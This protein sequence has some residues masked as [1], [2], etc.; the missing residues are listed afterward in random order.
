MKRMTWMKGAIAVA[1]MTGVSWALAADHRDAPKAI[2]DPTS[3]IND[4]YTWLDGSNVVLVM[5]VTPLATNMS[6]FS[7]KV[8]YV[9]HTESTAGFGQAGVPLDII[10]TFAVDQTIECW[11]GNKD[12]VKGDGEG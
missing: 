4:V 11:V 3:D 10:C 1:L 6:K 2:S 9:F 8:Q 5:S 7:D 12:Y